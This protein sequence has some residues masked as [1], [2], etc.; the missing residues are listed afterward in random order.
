MDPEVKPKDKSSVELIC[1]TC[2]KPISDKAK[3]NVTRFLFAESRCTCQQP[4]LVETPAPPSPADPGT[5][6]ETV[7]QNLGDKY[8]VL[9][10]LGKGGMGAVYKV[11]DRAL[12]KTLAIKVLNPSL[13]ED[14]NSVK[15]FE[16]EAKAASNLTHANLCAVYGYG[17]GKQGAPY[18]V[19]D[20]LD[21]KNLADIIAQ[22]GFLDVPRALDLFIQMAEAL[23]HAHMKGVVHRDIKPNNIIVEKGEDDIELVK[24][25]DFGIA[26][27]LPSETK[28][29]A[30]L[31]QTGEILGSPLYMS[32]EQC[33]GNKLDTRTDIYAMG[34]V[35]YEALTGKAPFQA[36]NPVKIIL[37]H[38][39]D[40]PVRISD[41]PGDYNVPRDFER[42]IFHCLEK[43]PDNR[44][45]TADD[46]LL[47]LQRVRDGKAL[48]FKRDPLSKPKASP[49]KPTSRQKLPVI[50]L[51]ACIP[52]LG[53]IIWLNWSKET[54]SPVKT[55]A[56]LTGDPYTDAERLDQLSYQYFVNGQY[57]KA[58]PYLEFGIK[59][60]KEGGRHFQNPRQEDQWLAD[61][62]QHI[63]KCYLKMHDYQKAVPYYQKALRIYNKVGK[64]GLMD[65]AVTDY[66]AVLKELGKT[67][68]AESLVNEYGKLPQQGK[69]STIP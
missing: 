24:I 7:V 48:R 47:D 13:V 1:A 64:W 28:A 40:N 8:E 29:T 61:Q 34:C 57:E 16:Q 62:I 27:V 18:L 65:E 20:Y 38:I 58:I 33:L 3:G 5:I 59:V 53:G 37:K 6:D 9:G 50:A 12:N 14:K 69:L 35:M 46:L 45:Q 51:A 26:K 32:P 15:R 2:G 22:E 17:V 49:D 25:V 19:M 31:T 66:A 41:L 68:S 10:L 4:V 52:I 30:N 60:Y 11:R 43:T 56:A 67:D 55:G 21:G 42:I 54:S 36:E 44:Y 39:N 23:S 63:G